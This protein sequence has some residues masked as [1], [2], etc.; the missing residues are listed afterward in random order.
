MSGQSGASGIYM[1]RVL[2][3]ARLQL[4][5]AA[6]I[7]VLA[8]CLV[9]PAYAVMLV[10]LSID[11]TARP[12]GPKDPV[13]T[14]QQQ[15][16]VPGGPGTL[17]MT[18]TEDRYVGGP[19]GFTL[20]PKDLSNDHIG[21]GGS[22]EYT[23]HTPIKSQLYRVQTIWRSDFS[24]KLWVASLTARHAYQAFQI[25]DRGQ[26]LASSQR[27]TL[28]FIP[29]TPTNQ[30][31]GGLSA[32]QSGLDGSWDW[33]AG[34]GIVV[35]KLDGT[36]ND[37]R[38]N[39][40]KWTIRDAKA[41]LFELKWSHGYTDRATLSADGNSLSVVNNVGTTFVAT[42]RVTP[43]GHPRVPNGSWNWGAGGGI[44]EIRPDGTGNDARGNTLRWTALDASTG[45]YE[46]KWSHG[47][48]DKATLSADGNSL[49]VRNNVGTRFVATRRAKP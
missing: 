42:R 11:A 22:T 15:F 14:V 28:E 45:V 18:Y 46:L 23:P 30:T 36:G 31:Q 3:R 48:T 19:G 6:V 20:D 40:M 32:P 27:L 47:Y 2:E 9:T 39:T 7:G 16:S 17:I 29:G 21:W 49:V 41:G 43:P 8:V 13:I 33:G 37:S 34:G 44:V 4:L 10:N 1:P 35:I 25:Q 5:I 24:K 12:Y 26:Q 38:G